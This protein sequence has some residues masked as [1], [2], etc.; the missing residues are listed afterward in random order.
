MTRILT[1]ALALTAACVAPPVMAQATSP[2]NYVKQAGASDL[3]EMQSSK[4]VLATSKNAGLRGYADEMIK[5]HSKSTADVKAAA[6]KAGL[7]PMPPKLMPMQES[8]VAKLR[9]A[10]G[11]ARDQLYVTQQKASHQMALQLQQGYAAHG[12]SAPLK[13][14]AAKIT[15]VVQ[16]HLAMLGKM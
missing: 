7:H 3:Y 10:S 1:T 9:A 8:D 11:P 2:A 14:V 16:H 5:D 12:T 4:L 13:A 6:M 15:P